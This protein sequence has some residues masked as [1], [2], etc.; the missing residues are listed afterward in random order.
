MKNNVVFLNCTQKY[1][2]QFSASNTK[3]ELMARGL[4]EQG[5]DIYIIDGLVG[6]KGQNG[7]LD[8]LSNIG[9]KYKIYPFKLHQL[10]S[11][12]FNL[13]ILYVDLKKTR[14]KTSKNV[15]IIENPDYHLFLVYIL[16]AKLLGFKVA[17]IFQEWGIAVKSDHP[18]R[19]PSKWIFIKSFG[20]FVDGIMPISQFLEEKSIHFNKKILRVPI[21]AEYSPVEYKPLLKE[22]VIEGYF[23]YCALAAYKSAVS[24]VIDAYEKFSQ[25]G[26]KQKFV[27]ILSGSSHDIM[28]AQNIINQKKLTDSIII[29]TKLPYNELLDYYKKANALLIPLDPNS[30]QDKSRFSQ[31]IAEYISSYRPIITSNVG[32]IP[33]YFNDKENAFI[34]SDYSPEGYASTM[35]EVVQNYELANKVGFNGR[36]VGEKKFNYKVYGSKLHLFF[37]KL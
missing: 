29:K 33:F 6:N 3:V 19:Q 11:W 4:I 14:S 36:D 31:K 17:T 37:K 8:G 7:A 23:L 18:L 26:G 28:R 9:I 20:Y 22:D 1:P 13:R 2:L 30:L 34:V 10:F 15:L 16:Y 35:I 27:V 12:L 25:L 32:E 21:L 24:F 5:D